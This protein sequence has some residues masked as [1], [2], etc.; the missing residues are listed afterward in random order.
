MKNNIKIK[1][2]YL[3]GPFID[4]MSMGGLAFLVFLCFY[5][6]VPDKHTAFWI[7]ASTILAHLINHPHFAISYLIFYKNFPQKLTS[8]ESS[9]SLKIRYWIAG[10]FVPLAIATLFITCLINRD[11]KNLGLS[12]NVMFL[13][14][15]WHYVKQG[16]GCLMVYSNL[17]QRYFSKSFKDILLLN[18]LFCWIFSWLSTNQFVYKNQFWGLEYAS[19]QMPQNY[20]IA[21]KYICL[22]LGLVTLLIFIYH[23]HKWRSRFPF[24]GVIAYLSAIYPWT[25]FPSLDPAFVLLIPLFHS[26]QYLLISSKYQ[27]NSMNFQKIELQSEN[28]TDFQMFL[29]NKYSFCLITLILGYFLFWGIPNFIQDHSSINHIFKNKVSVASF[30]FWIFINIHHY[31]MDAVMWRKQNQDIK[32]FLFK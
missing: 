26:I 28:P 15:G 6:L 32:K 18:A 7:S 21:S 1:H 13:L 23:C 12:V 8:N 30:C 24:I 11:A 3:Y 19:F 25:I 29:V 20:L 22:F 16:Y 31:F 9:N 27:L 4:F 10:I 17:N 2:P 14:V 5:Y